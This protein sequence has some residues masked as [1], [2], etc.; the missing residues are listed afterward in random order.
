MT[1]HVTCH[2]VS[3]QKLHRAENGWVMVY[4]VNTRKALCVIYF[5]HGQYSLL[6]GSLP[7][8][9]Y[10]APQMSSHLLRPQKKLICHRQKRMSWF[11]GGKLLLGIT[12]TWASVSCHCGCVELRRKKK[13]RPV[14]MCIITWQ[15]VLH[16]KWGSTENLFLNI[17]Q[18]AL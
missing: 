15:R 5:L 7:G 4:Y 11:W 3:H 14:V 8:E 17:K 2:S 9:F 10:S 18:S 13:K 1:C 16:L 6:Q 12:S